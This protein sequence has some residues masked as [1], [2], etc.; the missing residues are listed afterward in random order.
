MAK[1]NSI[2]AAEIA[3]ETLTITVTGIATPIVLDTADLP[4]NLN[5][6]ARMHGY[7]QRI[8]DGAAIPKADLSP[9]PVAAAKQKFAAMSAIAD[10][11]RDG[12]WSKRSGDGSGP[13]AGLI[14]R[15]FVLYGTEAAAKAKRPAPTDEQFRAVYDAKTRAEQLAMRSIPRIAE[16]IETLK[17]ERGTKANAVDASALLGELGL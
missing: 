13:V 8:C 17:A 1:K 2:I 11:L 4:A 14:Y 15:A 9:D 7:K 5:L 6:A 10:A 16:I 12:D 3:G